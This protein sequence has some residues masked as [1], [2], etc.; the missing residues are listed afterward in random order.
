MVGG[1]L[2]NRKTKLFFENSTIITSFPDAGGEE[3]EFSKLINTYRYRFEMGIIDIHIDEVPISY[4]RRVNCVYMPVIMTMRMQNRS[5][6]HRSVTVNYSVLL[7]IRAGSSEITSG[8][9]VGLLEAN[10]CVN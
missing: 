8:P 3:K 5:D 10:K 7:G 1:D 4:Y 6:S 9:V 2:L